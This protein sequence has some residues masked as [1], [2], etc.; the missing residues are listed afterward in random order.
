MRYFIE[1]ILL[2]DKVRLPDLSQA[3]PLSNSSRQFSSPWQG[4][5]AIRSVPLRSDKSAGHFAD[6]RGTIGIHASL[7]LPHPVLLCFL[8][9]RE[10]QGAYGQG[11]RAGNLNDGNTGDVH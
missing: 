7:M 2:S 6:D 5:A 10:Q 11:N 8:Q 1:D 9:A 4:F 3:A